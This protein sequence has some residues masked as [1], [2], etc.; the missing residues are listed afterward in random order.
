MQGNLRVEKELHG[1][2][3][4]CAIFWCKETQGNFWPGMANQI[5]PN[6]L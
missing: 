5:E 3:R 6:W 4:K 1:N 2:T